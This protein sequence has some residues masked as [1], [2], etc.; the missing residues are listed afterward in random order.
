MQS[1]NSK[2]ITKMEI[3]LENKVAYMRNEISCLEHLKIGTLRNT[4]VRE[5][6]IK[7]HHLEVKTVAEIIETNAQT[8]CN[9]NNFE[10]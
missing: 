5:R 10:N 3:R 2:R 9:I 8:T 6:I 4:K 7:K 1:K